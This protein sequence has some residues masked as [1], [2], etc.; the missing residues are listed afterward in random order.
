MGDRDHGV[1]NIYG[2]WYAGH[3]KPWM[4]NP[5]EAVRFTF[6]EAQRQADH[7]FYCN[8]FTGGVRCDSKPVVIGAAGMSLWPQTSGRSAPPHYAATRA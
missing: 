8:R 1:K 6:A 7:Y 3:E 5:A 4:Y 2:L